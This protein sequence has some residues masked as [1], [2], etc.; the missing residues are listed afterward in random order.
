MNRKTHTHK[1]NN[2][3]PTYYSRNIGLKN[4]KLRK[5]MRKGSYYINICKTA[6]R[7][8]LQLTL[9]EAFLNKV[10]SCEIE[11]LLYLKISLVDSECRFN[12]RIKY[13]TTSDFFIY[14]NKPKIKCWT[15][16]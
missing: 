5:W 14:I 12:K 8:L 9:K 1:Y 13:I 2:S 11:C 15:R 10:T 7:M 16:M 4:K 3:F 6:T